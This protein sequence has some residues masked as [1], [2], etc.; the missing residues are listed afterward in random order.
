MPP[1]MTGV[2][3]P[4]DDDVLD[5][6][7]D[8]YALS[9]ILP[10]SPIDI[11][12]DV[13]NTVFTISS[14]SR[15]AAE[16]ESTFRDVLMHLM[17]VISVISCREGRGRLLAARVCT[18][19]KNMFDPGV[20]PFDVYR[21]VLDMTVAHPSGPRS[22]SDALNSWRCHCLAPR[23]CNEPDKGGV[24][25]A[26]RRYTARAAWRRAFLCTRTLYRVTPVIALRVLI[27]SYMQ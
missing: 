24:I 27:V 14:L 8:Y 9:D 3:R 12:T 23:G 2:K 1:R 10:A 15:R 6:D 16:H 18:M 7:E 21:R 17:A 25:K 26:L 13:L 19:L 22:V 11:V 20:A 5:D 4:R